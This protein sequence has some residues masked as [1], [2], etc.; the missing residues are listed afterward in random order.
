MDNFRYQQKNILQFKVFH[1]ILAFAILFSFLSLPAEPVIINFFGLMPSSQFIWWPF[2]VYFLYKINI[3][4]GFEYYR[5]AVY[6]IVIFRFIYV[7]IIK[8]AITLPS[9]SFWELS[10]PF[11][12]IF[13]RDYIYIFFSSAKIWVA[14][15]LPVKLTHKYPFLNHIKLFNPLIS[16][17]IL[18]LLNLFQSNIIEDYI[19]TILIYLLI[20]CFL[21]FLEEKII[22]IENITPINNN[23]SLFRFFPQYN[24]ISV[25]DKIYL[26]YH[27][28]LFCSGVLFFITAKTISSKFISI[29][30]FTINAGGLV[31]SLA[32]IVAD[33]MTDAYGIERTKQLIYFIIF[34]NFLFVA[35]IWLTNQLLTDASAN[36]FFT[37]VFNNQT[38]IFL[39]SILSF[40]IGAMANGSLL[41]LFKQ[42][43]KSRK[44]SLKK[45]FLITVWL[46]V[47]TSTLLGIVTDVSLFSFIA[48]WGIV[49]G[50]QL[51]KIVFFENI[52]KIT[53]EFLITPLAILA[54][55]LI[56]IKE[57]IDIYDQLS[58]LNPFK[59]NVI[60]PVNSNKFY[61]NY[62]KEDHV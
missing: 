1:S 54:I 57:K 29:S 45:E 26:K 27:H 53:Y 48:F 32:Y 43:Q 18:C 59:I 11:S 17:L 34:S 16:L 38:W 49:P 2:V 62:T 12:H 56:K 52:Y 44:I 24:L 15:F 46:R 14:F 6:V 28:I 47:S 58:N 23:V 22:K 20:V 41:S 9:A 3:I 10:I 4:Y 7:L 60:Y 61:E 40:L 50:N 36:V 35:D 51:A 30:G 5:H 13:D 21:D 55:Y 39:A 8:L 42:R 19:S 25:P 31:F 33:I 37:L